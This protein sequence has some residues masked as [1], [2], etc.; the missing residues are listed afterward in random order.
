MG[1]K[2]PKKSFQIYT[3]HEIFLHSATFYWQLNSKYTTNL[4]PNIAIPKRNEKTPKK[5]IRCSE[6]NM[7]LPI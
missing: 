6:K 7:N 5:S 2:K 3:D 4:K 1:V